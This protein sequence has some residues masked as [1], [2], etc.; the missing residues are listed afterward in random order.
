[1]E[2]EWSCK[3]YVVETMLIVVV[4]VIVHQ[5]EWLADGA[6]K[7]KTRKEQKKVII[8]SLCRRRNGHVT[9]IKTMYRGRS[10]I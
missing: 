9:F 10:D 7:L 3:I 1:M 2:E 6:Y 8:G 4:M 5:L